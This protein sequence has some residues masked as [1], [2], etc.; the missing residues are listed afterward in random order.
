MERAR[1]ES[2]RLLATLLVVSISQG[3]EWREPT[4]GDAERLKRV[5]ADLEAIVRDRSLLGSL[6]EEERARLLRAAAD[7]HEPDIVQRRRWAKA[8]R[9]NEKAA[10][11]SR[12]DAVLA[13]TGIRLLRAKPVFTT[14][15]VFPPDGFEQS[16]VTDDPG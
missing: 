16:E 12:D 13:A 8:V 2:A 10:K 6:T 11:A 1:F 3:D 14:P 9:R 4:S 7:V 5:I 15:N